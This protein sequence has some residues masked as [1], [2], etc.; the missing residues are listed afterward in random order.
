M[1]EAGK[2]QQT[3]DAVTT[4]RKRLTSRGEDQLTQE[5]DLD[6]TGSTNEPDRAEPAANPAVALGSAIMTLR[7]A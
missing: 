7:P 6:F 1:G 2:E 3:I 5:S 4:A